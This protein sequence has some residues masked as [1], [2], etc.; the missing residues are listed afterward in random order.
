VGLVV[1]GGGDLAEP[2]AVLTGV[3]GAEQQ[4]PTCLELDAEVGLGAATVAAVS[5]A[6]RGDT[7]G[8]SGGHIGLISSVRPGL[9]MWGST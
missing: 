8:N 5:G 9:S 4:L 3:V 7:R 1:H 2:V 6:Q